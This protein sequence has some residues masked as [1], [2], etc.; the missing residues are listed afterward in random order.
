M[1][2]LRGFEA[3]GRLGVY[4]TEA[5]NLDKTLIKLAY[6]AQEKTVYLLSKEII[7]LR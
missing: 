4:I 3:S 1:S 6:S 5:Q 2:D 7:N